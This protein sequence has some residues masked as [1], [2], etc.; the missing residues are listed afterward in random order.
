MG[1]ASG[2]NPV[3]GGPSS[4]V[5]KASRVTARNR[6]RNVYLPDRMGEGG[7]V[8]C[9]RDRNV[10]LPDSMGRTGLINVTCFLR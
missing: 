6:D 1:L 3:G 5:S 10:Y 2:G 9:D 4:L 8:R 7:N